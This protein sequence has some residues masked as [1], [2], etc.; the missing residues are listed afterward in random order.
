VN[1]ILND[2]S[3]PPKL[4]LGQAYSSIWLDIRSLVSAAMPIW[5]LPTRS[6]PCQRSAWS[7]VKSTRPR[8]FPKQFLLSATLTALVC[9]S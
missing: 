5:L 9:S 1:H 4:N 3:E 2:V 8:K 6:H 7:F